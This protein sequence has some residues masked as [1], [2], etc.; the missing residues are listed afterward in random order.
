M[1]VDGGENCCRLYEELESVI[2]VLE[3]PSKKVLN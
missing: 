1:V 3:L 2:N